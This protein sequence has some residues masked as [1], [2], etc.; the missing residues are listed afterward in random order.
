MAVHVLVCDVCVLYSRIEEVYAVHKLQSFKRLKFLRPSTMVSDKHKMALLLLC[1]PNIA[2]MR[3]PYRYKIAAGI[4]SK[5]SS[6]K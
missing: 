5:L 6:G 3:M 2:I 1:A 4:V